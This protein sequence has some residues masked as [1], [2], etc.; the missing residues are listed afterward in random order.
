MNR[1]K[2]LHPYSGILKVLEA[3]LLIDLSRI[4]FLQSRSKMK[5]KNPRMI[6]R[7][8][9]NLWQGNLV[10]LSI[11]RY[12]ISNEIHWILFGFFIR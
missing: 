5:F 10:I 9:T 1:T 3:P 12:S 7:H 8:L 11:R 2:E 6:K 4:R